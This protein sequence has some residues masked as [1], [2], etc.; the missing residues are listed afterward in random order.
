MNRV[1]IPGRRSRNTGCVAFLQQDLI[2]LD[3]YTVVG[4]SY[5]RSLLRSSLL[6]FHKL[7][8]CQDGF[9]ALGQ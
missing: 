9:V 4:G 6:S 8:P 3:D 7:R 2:K 1:S 5:R